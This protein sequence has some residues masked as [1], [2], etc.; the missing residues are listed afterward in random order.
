[1]HSRDDRS[2]R[3]AVNANPHAT[4][5]PVSR[6]PRRRPA[7]AKAGPA[8]VA[9]LLASGFV[10]YAIVL[11][12][13][14]PLAHL[15][16]SRPPTSTQAMV[17]APAPEE[18]SREDRHAQYLVRSTLMALDDAH[19]TGNYAVL[20]QL[21]SPAFQTAN[22]AERLAEAFA[23]QRRQDLDL[24]VAALAQPEWSQSPAV[25]DDNL[26]RLAGSYGLADSGR[27]TFALVF[28]PAGGVWRL[29]EI[30][31]GQTPRQTG[32]V[33]AAGLR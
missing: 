20:R 21:A 9:M 16:P 10:S 8:M 25:G 23:A 15:M 26:L 28:A 18:A 24:S 29:Y 32:A 19:R 4:L 2:A 6:A 30:H 5:E 12:A 31:V 1:M 33:R 13:D 17:L 14:G 22:S 7:A 3:H 11:G 27:L